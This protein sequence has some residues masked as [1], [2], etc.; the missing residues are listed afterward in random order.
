MSS[1]VPPADLCPRLN[2]V[3][4]NVV[5]T[6][7]QAEGACRFAA[8]HRFAS[9]MVP[10]SMAPLAQSALKGSGVWLEVVVDAPFGASTQAHKETVVAQT[11]SLE[12]IGGFG[13]VV[14]HTAMLD[15]RLGDVRGELRAC[16]K[17]SRRQLGAMFELSLLGGRSQRA[18]FVQALGQE[19]IKW[20]QPHVG[21]RQERGLVNLTAAE[22]LNLIHDV[23]GHLKLMAYAGPLNVWDAVAQL[24]GMAH[25]V[26]VDW[27]PAFAA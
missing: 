21:M 16:A 8:K 9:V 6:S 19:N 10:P 26:A 12:G 25:G 2:L 14:N 27:R 1:F 24:A 13:V 5:L 15:G 3:L 20:L 11:A 23:A 18:E 4:Y 7:A 22:D 17:Q